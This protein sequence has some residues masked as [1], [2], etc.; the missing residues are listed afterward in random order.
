ML[1]PRH[2]SVRDL[3]GFIASHL[4]KRLK[5][6][7]HYIVACDWKRN[8]HMPVSLPC[9]SNKEKLSSL[10]PLLRD[11]PLRTAHALVLAGALDSFMGP[12]LPTTVKPHMWADRLRF[13]SEVCI[14]LEAS[15]GSAV[16]GILLG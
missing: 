13:S 4:A 9:E 16:H 7:G 5:S 8:E 15:R 12:V 14:C 1:I 11:K 10:H 2:D 3:A 6:E